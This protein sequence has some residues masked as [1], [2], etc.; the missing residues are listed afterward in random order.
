M[1]ASAPG[2][3]AISQQYR[4]RPLFSLLAGAAAGCCGRADRPESRGSGGCPG[5]TTLTFAVR[6]RRSCSPGHFATDPPEVTGPVLSASTARRATLYILPVVLTWRCR[7]TGIR[8]GRPVRSMVSVRTI[9]PPRPG[10]QRQPPK[11]TAF[12]VSGALPA[13]PAVCT[14]S[15]SKGGAGSS[16]H[17]FE[18]FS[19]FVLGAQHRVCSLAGHLLR[20]PVRPTAGCKIVTG[21]ASC[22]VL[23]LPRCLAR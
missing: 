6:C 10:P 18:A 13:W 19:C 3:P 17:C 15:S 2:P 22:R 5:R 12:S 4:R 21:A 8:R 16:P 9:V 20:T 7:V 11:L 1:Q 14:P 23:V